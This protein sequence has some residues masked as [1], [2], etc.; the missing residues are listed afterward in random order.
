MPRR[1]TAQLRLRLLVKMASERGKIIQSETMRR[2][3][4][5]HGSQFNRCAC[6][7]LIKPRFLQQEQRRRAV[8]RCTRTDRTTA[9]SRHATSPHDRPTDSARCRIKLIVSSAT[10]SATWDHKPVSVAFFCY[11]SITVQYTHVCMIVR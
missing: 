3:A 10:A 9:S 6:R 2:C 4:A 11:L 7:M 1:Q 5:R 8:S